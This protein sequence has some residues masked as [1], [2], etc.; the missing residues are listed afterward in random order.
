LNEPHLHERR[1]NGNADRLRSPERMALLEVEHVVALSM[2]DVSLKS[3]LDVGTGTAIFAEAF[4]Q[5]G[6]Q[7]GGIDTN[8][9]L[10]E[11]A[12]R[13]VP[14][15][16]FREALAEAIP[17][18]DDSFDLVFLGHVLHETDDPLKALQEAR[19]VAKSRVV[20]LE[21]PYREDAQAGP[22]MEHRLK[23][24]FIKDIA[25]KAGFL[26]VERIEL[27]HM[28]YYRLTP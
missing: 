21:W 18:E 13:H 7:V 11:V 6:L 17:F 1:F 22:P 23:P 8:P 14:S 2:E 25:R 20:I 24:D 16:D 10:L 9:K 5:Q 27:Q 15:G 12:R 19:R 26:S 28:D 3:M 4:F